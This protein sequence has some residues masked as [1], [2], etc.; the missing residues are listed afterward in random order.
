MKERL[1]AH[2]RT[3][4]V[5][6]VYSQI[7][8]AFNQSGLAA[9]AQLVKIFSALEPIAVNL[10]EAINRQHIESE[11]EAKDLVR[12][13]NIR[14]LFLFLQ[15]SCHH[16]VETLKEAAQ[17]LMPVL[18]RYGLSIIQENYVAESGFVEALLTDLAAADL[19]S[20]IAAVSGCAELIA[21]V[22]T[23][24][25][26]FEA[27][28][29][30]FKNGKVAEANLANATRTKQN[31]VRL[32]NKTLVNYLTTMCEIDEENYGAFYRIVEQLIYDN[33]ALVRARMTAT[34]KTVQA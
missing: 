28:R 12:D 33:N 19:Q 6:N 14:S 29:L 4:E 34:T 24:Q 31:L 2:G 1:S 10:N 16:P 25:D 22:K 20:S 11:L 30:S 23:A 8:S 7:R 27:T 26:D 3:T 32:L 15:G 18:D 21:G 9:E 5:S 17:K 13:N